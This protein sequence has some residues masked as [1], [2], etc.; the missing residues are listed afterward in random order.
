MA[1][2]KTHSPYYI[3][4]NQHYEVMQNKPGKREKSDKILV[5]NKP[6]KRDKSDKILVHTGRTG[7]E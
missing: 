6:G 4:F 3:L 2:Y 1:A 7:D 5:Q